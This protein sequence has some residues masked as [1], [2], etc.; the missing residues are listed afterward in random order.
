MR[1]TKFPISETNGCFRLLADGSTY[2]WNTPAERKAAMEACQQHAAEL[3][4][5]LRG[6]LGRTADRQGVY[7]VLRGTQGCTARLKSK[8][9]S[10]RGRNYPGAG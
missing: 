7:E 5:V 1:S 3:E 8:T 6:K 4:I 10:K 2:Y 9:R